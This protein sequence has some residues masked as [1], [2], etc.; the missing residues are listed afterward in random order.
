M[1]YRVL[2]KN[3]A[4]TILILISL[5]L[6]ACSSSPTPPREAPVVEE[7]SESPAA[8]G[9]ALYV[10]QTHNQTNSPSLTLYIGAEPL[11]LAAGYVRLVGVI[12]GKVALIEVGGRGVQAK[13]G[14]KIGEYLVQ[15]IEESEVDLCLKK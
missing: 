12:A 7:K 9:S 14:D 13:A 2:M 15:S 4:Y 5:G 8:A 11:A 3:L 6:S 1:L 10:Y